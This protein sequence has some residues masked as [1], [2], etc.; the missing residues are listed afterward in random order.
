FTAP[1]YGL[2][3][4]P[5]GTILLGA[6]AP[7]VSPFERGSDFAV[8]R[9]TDE[10]A[11]WR[12]VPLEGGAGAVVAALTFLADGSVLAGGVGVAMYPRAGFYR[13]TDDG[14]TWTRVRDNVFAER[15]SVVPG[16]RV[17][18]G[19]PWNSHHSDDGGLT[20]T[21]FEYGGM[22]VVVG[23]G[24]GLLASTGH[25][26]IVRSDDGGATWTDAT[27]GFGRAEVGHVTVAPDGTIYAAQ[28]E[29]GWATGLHRSTDRGLTWTRHAMPFEYSG[30]HDL[31]ADGAGRVFA[32]P[33][34]CCGGG[35]GGGLFRSDD[36]GVSW[37]DVTPG[38]RSGYL[39]TQVKQLVRQRGRLWVLADSLYASDDGGLMWR[40]RPLRAVTFTIGPDGTFWAT[41]GHNVVRSTNEGTSWQIV[42]TFPS[43][44]RLNAVGPLR[45]GA[46]VLSAYEDDFRSP[47]GGATWVP[48]DFSLGARHQ[49]VRTFFQAPDG[50]VYAAVD[51]PP[52]L[53]RSLDDGVTWVPAS[54]GLPG[55]DAYYADLAVDP[56]GRLL[57]ALGRQGLY[58]TTGVV[59]AAS[60][61]LI[62]PAALVIRVAPNPARGVTTVALTL[63]ASVRA[64]DVS[65]FDVTGRRVARL[66]EGAAAGTLSLRFDGAG[67][68]A[69]LYHVRAQA[70]GARAMAPLVLV[71]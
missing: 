61:A 20:W 16:G 37:R 8:W 52:P 64:L 30:L 17:Y 25:L 9:S 35:P 15:F 24:G 13:S 63:P 43:V 19:H 12:P 4:G 58:Q 45:S 69:G 48:L 29:N 21:P 66:H 65:V 11:T 36:G 68:P 44:V 7:P 26:G 14:R 33:Q 41:G 5:G 32:A 1:S 18:A 60:P 70:A 53:M 27:E 54:T 50:V 55:T 46:V 40:G 23:P 38:V 2:A 10:A 51:G 71:R 62:S 67:L 34:R 28:P 31:I 6:P 3:I 39:R 47:D 56:S 22:G 49:E 57:L 59:V 42:G